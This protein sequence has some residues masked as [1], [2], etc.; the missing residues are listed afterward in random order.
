VTRAPA[1][2]A[3]EAELTG[4]EVRRWTRHAAAARADTT[5]WTQLGDAVGTLTSIA[6][7]VAVVGGSVASLRERVLLAGSPVTPAQLPGGFVAAV[8]GVLGL[9]ALLVLLDRLGPV[10]ATPAVAAW[11][12]PLP[13]GRGGLLA[14]ELRRV[15]IVSVVPAVL[16]AFPVLIT[17]SERPSAAGVLGGVAVVAGVVAAAVGAVALLQTAGRTGR[18][19]AVA[20]G[21]AVAVAVLTAALGTVGGPAVARV[22]G[23]PAPSLP[24]WA[25][26]VPAAVAVVLLA[27]ASHRL[28]RLPAGQLRA[29]GAVASY[30]AASA[31]TLDTRDLGR[32]LGARN[33]RG[34]ARSRRFATVQQPW[35]AVVAADATTLL[36]SRWQL[37]QLGV[38]IAVPVVVAR[39]VG[40]GELRPAVWVGCAVGGALAATAAGHPA[41]QAQAAPVLDRLLPLSPVEVVR[42]RL[43][44]PLLL[45]TVVCGAAGLLVALGST[46]AWG[47]LLL[48]T[49]PT[50]AA[51]AVRGAYRPELDWSG[52]VMATPVGP[53]PVGTGATLVQGP[54][55]GVLGTLPLGVALLGA[56]PTAG[57]IVFQLTWSVALAAGAVA[58]TA[59]R[60]GRPR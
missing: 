59:R 56:G 42:A 23:V 15:V 49:A 45:T 8:A 51:A 26:A 2:A 46:P 54:D 1:A 60:L 47:L 27:V 13:A 36:R 11:W 41:R 34:P 17:V 57:L 32:A 58:L 7:G 20:G 22:A 4:R 31:F 53:V 14:G 28:D 21:V 37:G 48:A 10:N 55:V 25:S 9:A 16:L 43:A 24:G 52:Q 39:T 33:V 3:P 30:A 38:A 35:Q 6:V 50:W 5:L 12:L 29:R 18:L 19:A 44:V 40:L